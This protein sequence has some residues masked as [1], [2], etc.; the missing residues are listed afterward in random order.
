MKIEYDQH[1]TGEQS[2]EIQWMRETEPNVWITESV[3]CDLSDCYD[4]S[5]KLATPDYDKS[6]E[7]IQNGQLELKGYI[8]EL[9]KEEEIGIDKDLTL[10]ILENHL[11]K[12]YPNEL[13]EII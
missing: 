11:K 9:E 5:Y 2:I 4:Q 1:V 7:Y 6:G 3:I 13:I 8:Q 10:E 12:T